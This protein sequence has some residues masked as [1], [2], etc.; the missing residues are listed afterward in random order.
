MQ[1][2]LL[3]VSGWVGSG[4]SADGLGWVTQ[5]GFMDNSDR[6]ACSSGSPVQSLTLSIHAVLG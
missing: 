4:Q 2:N 5:N 3:V 6:A 1:I